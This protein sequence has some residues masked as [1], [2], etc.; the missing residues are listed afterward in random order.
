VVTPLAPTAWTL[1]FDGKTVS[2]H[3]SVGS[4]SLPCR[5][6]YFITR[7]K[8]VWAS[9]WT[10]EQVAKGRAQEARA[11]DEYFN[12]VQST[13]GREEP[14]GGEPHVVQTPTGGLWRKIKGWFS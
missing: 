4:W 5:S 3:P 2:L 8:V 1:T 11:R 14:A 12:N 7:N 9:P 13:A 6:H 10:P